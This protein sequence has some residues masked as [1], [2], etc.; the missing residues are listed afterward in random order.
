MSRSACPYATPQR[1][2]RHLS[3]NSQCRWEKTSQVVVWDELENALEHPR[4]NLTLIS[5]NFTLISIRLLMGGCAPLRD[6]CIGSAPWAATGRAMA[7]K[8]PVILVVLSSSFRQSGD[9]SAIVFQLIPVKASGSSPWACV[10]RQLQGKKH[11]CK[12]GLG[13]RKSLLI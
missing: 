1:W 6:A 10:H 7:S 5:M 11:S 3:R 8:A 13:T 2:W 12:Q 4:Q 9:Q